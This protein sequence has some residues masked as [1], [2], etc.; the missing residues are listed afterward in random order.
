[1]R[2]ALLLATLLS[3]AVPALAE[4]PVIVAFGDSI[5]LGPGMQPADTYPAQLEAL[6][7]AR[8]GEAA[9]RVVN[10]GVGGNTVLAGL[11]RLDKDVL[12]L[13][14][15]FVL[16]GFGMNDSVMVATDQPRVPLE[17]FREKLTELVGRVQATGAQTLLASVTPVLDEYYF[18]RHP[19]EW[20]PEGLKPVLE[21]YGAV[22]GEVART[23]RSPLVD[24][25]GLDPATQIRNPENSGLRDG[26]HPNAAGY[27]VIAAAYAKALAP[28]L[29]PAQ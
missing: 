22:I 16:I 2:K 15:R 24:L 29:T 23:T 13:Q 14:P 20:Y 25:S 21:R 28:L 26:V 11:A 12:A 19:R 17:Q 9:P 27:A 7:V 5:T 8:L 18:D 3:A 10:A 1:M 4:R 6:L